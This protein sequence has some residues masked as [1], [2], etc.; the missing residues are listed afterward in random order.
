VRVRDLGSLV[1]TRVNGELIGARQARSPQEAVNEV[2]STARDLHDGDKVQ[3]A[4]VVIQ[5]NIA[6]FSPPFFPTGPR[7]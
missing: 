3:L 4:D 7:M 5:V 6:E 2:A 1:G